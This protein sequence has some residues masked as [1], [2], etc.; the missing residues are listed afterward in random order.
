MSEV[1]SVGKYVIRQGQGPISYWAQHGVDCFSIY[2]SGLVY[3]QQ[4]P[5][6]RGGVGYTV[7]EVVSRQNIPRN[8]VLALRTLDTNVAKK[9][10]NVIKDELDE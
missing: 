9:C 10:W 6:N 4:I 2:G 3:R 7:P 5:T 8:L 1:R